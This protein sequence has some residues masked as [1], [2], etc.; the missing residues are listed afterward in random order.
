MSCLIGH[1]RD[2][3]LRMMMPFEDLDAFVAAVRP[4]IA[5]A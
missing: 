2:P 5:D 4:F 1:G 3:E